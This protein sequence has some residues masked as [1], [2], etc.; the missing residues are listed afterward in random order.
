VDIID[1]WLRTSGARNPDAWVSTREAYDSFR[2]FCQA[3]GANA[4]AGGIQGFS[5]KLE[6]RLIRQRKKIGRG[7]RGLRLEETASG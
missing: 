7:W 2:R 3:A 1:R 6:R 5:S 4:H